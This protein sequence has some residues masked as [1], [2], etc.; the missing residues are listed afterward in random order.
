[1]ERKTED[2]FY[3]RILDKF[4]LYAPRQHVSALLNRSA[5]LA[6]SAGVRGEENVSGEVAGLVQLLQAPGELVPAP[7]TGALDDP[8]FLGL[9][10][11][12]GCNLNCTYC[13]FVAPKQG[14]PH[15]EVELARQA[16]EAYI[17]LLNSAG[18]TDLEVHFF[19]GEPFAAWEVVFFALEYARL[20]AAEQGLEARFE[21]ITNGVFDE[22]RCRWIGDHFDTVVLSL[23]GMDGTQDR[24]RPA[25]N[26]KPTL[27]T[28]LRNARILADGPAE[29]ALRACITQD[30]VGQMVEYALWAAQEL[31]PA[32]LCFETLAESPRSRQAG[33]SAADGLAFAQNFIAAKIALQAYGVQVV[34]ST[35]PPGKC[36]TSFCPLGKDA[37][38]VSPDGSVDG[39]YWLEGE[40]QKQGL[41]LHLGWVEPDGFAFVPGKVQQVRD[42]TGRYKTACQD[43]LC[44]YHCA[45]GCHVRRGTA[46]Q[47]RRYSEVCFQTRAITAARLLVEMGQAELAQAW[48]QDRQAVERMVYAP[49]DRLGIGEALA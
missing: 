2:I 36:Q 26:G 37:L 33:L 47:G 15:M 11:T 41:D 18:K 35:D 20:Q 6:V 38:I 21:V 46:D 22:A 23:D 13:D 32:S 8:F 31:R 19:G 28:I 1:M 34:L 39:C 40:W 9:I 10:P 3:A 7:R 44:Q 25:L 43:C 27:A 12:R 42:A 14:S 4:L 49:A 16:I 29:L 30:N 24:Q 48:L 45:G 5:A 17:Q